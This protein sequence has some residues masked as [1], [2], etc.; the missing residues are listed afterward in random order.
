M[1]AATGGIT[2][3]TWSIVAGTLPPG[4]QLNTSTG[5]I[6]G[7]ASGAGVSNFTVQV[8]D[9]E[10]PP[11]TASKALS[12]TISPAVPL[13]ITTT[14]LPAGTAGSPYSAPITAIGG[15]YPYTWSVI[16][17]KIPDGLT[18]NSS[19]GVLAGTPQNVGVSNFTVQVTDAETPAVSVTAQLSL[20]I[21][22]PGGNGNPGLLSGNYAFYLNG[23]NAS[24]Q[25]T[26][27]GSFISDGNGNITSGVVDGNPLAG[28]PFTSN[29]TGTYSISTTGL[30][31][32]TLQG[33][34]YGPATFA[35][36]LASSGNGRII[37]YDD[38]TG[39]GSRGSGVLRKATPAA[40]SLSALNGNWVLGMTGGDRTGRFVDAGVFTL[41][42]G[43][44]S[45]GVSDINDTGTYFTGTFFGNLSSIDAQTGRGVATIQTSF[46][47]VRHEAT[48]VVSSTEMILEQIDATPNSGIPVCVGSVMQ[49]SGTFNNGSLNGT[50]VM[51]MQDIHGGDGKDQSQAGL[52]ASTVTATL[53]SLLSMRIWPAR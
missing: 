33:Q 12:I 49:Q 40:F 7:T 41:A 50:S 17:G 38:P 27:A 19:T 43:N 6:S 18:L 53:T 15:V 45:N 48:Y 21:N 52:S 2:P 36:V 32:I 44:L 8:A 31:L 14:S 35:F 37:E 42:A 23:F 26:L 30:N 13:S 24:G 28:Q 34:S 16:F 51:Y 1:L 4:L 29:V 10:G 20:T 39:N 9:A 46:G 5:A 25:F 47:D 11:A 3:Y 22:S